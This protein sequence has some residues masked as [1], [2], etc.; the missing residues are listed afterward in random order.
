MIF[1]FEVHIK[2]GYSAEAY[3]DAWVRASEIIQNAEGARGTKLH[4]KM[5]DPNVLLAIASWE[6]KNQR[7]AQESNQSD[8]VR[9]IIEAE[10]EFVEVRVIG[11]FEDPDWEIKV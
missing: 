1:L 10:A 6:S 9:H 8:E 5:D 11:E 2:Q 4:R 7:D 3:A